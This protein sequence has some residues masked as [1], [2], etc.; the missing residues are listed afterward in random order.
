MCTTRSP[1]VRGRRI[2]RRP[3]GCERDPHPDRGPCEPAARHFEIRREISSTKV[4]GGC[5]ESRRSPDGRP[6]TT[7]L[8]ASRLGIY[9]IEVPAKHVG[10]E[11]SLATMLHKDSI[12]QLTHDFPRGQHIV[13]RRATAGRVRSTNLLHR[14]CI[15]EFA[16]S[17]GQ[18][19]IAEVGG[20]DP[21]T[22]QPNA[23]ASPCR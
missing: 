9:G 23:R 11:G 14:T 7:K 13:V 2:A 19:I 10:F 17:Q 16:V 1:A 6:G 18:T 5:P 20:K 21:A 4:A 12:V 3:N 8:A 22:A 15:V